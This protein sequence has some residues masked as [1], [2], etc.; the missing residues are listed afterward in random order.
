MGLEFLMVDTCIYVFYLLLDTN[1][2]TAV[3]L[4]TIERQ[5][6]HLKKMKIQILDLIL[7]NLEV[8]DL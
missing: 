4:M 5:M 8:L 1:F 7:Y 2:I 3:K 6:Q